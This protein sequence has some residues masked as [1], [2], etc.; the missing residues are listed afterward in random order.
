MNVVKFFLTAFL[1]STL[2]LY[3][4]APYKTKPATSWRSEGPALGPWRGKKRK[5]YPFPDWKNSSHHNRSKCFGMVFSAK[6]WMQIQP[7]LD[8]HVARRGYTCTLQARCRL[9]AKN[10]DSF[11][12]WCHLCIQELSREWSSSN[13][14]CRMHIL[15]SAAE[16]NKILNG[17]PNT[18]IGV[19]G[20][21]GLSGCRGMPSS[22]S[23]YQV[24]TVL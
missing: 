22:L 2:C 7:S 8:R 9:P 1:P 24:N 14:S 5:L 13:F 17:I 10:S 16:A 3:Y 4:L 12:E 6:C 21:C 23:S 18:V 19:E 15:L 20:P 11:S